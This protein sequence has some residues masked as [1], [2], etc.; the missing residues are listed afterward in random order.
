MASSTQFLRVR[1]KAASTQITF[2][3]TP[4]DSPG[5]SEVN[6]FT[7]SYLDSPNP[8]G[9]GDVKPHAFADFYIAYDASPVKFS[10]A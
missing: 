3:R 5:R 2:P 8:T 7:L 10:E 9:R 4:G 1:P 6:L